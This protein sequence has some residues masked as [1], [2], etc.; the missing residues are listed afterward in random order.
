MFVLCIYWAIVTFGSLGKPFLCSYISQDYFSPVF[1]YSLAGQSLQEYKKLST[2]LSASLFLFSSVLIHRPRS[3]TC[4]ALFQLAFFLQGNER[5]IPRKSYGRKT[6]SSR[7]IMAARRKGAM[8]TAAWRK[9][10]LM[11]LYNG[12]KSSFIMTRDSLKYPATSRF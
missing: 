11:Y 2:S 6:H 1:P 3:A 10:T 4:P 5:L 7:R 8:N 9:I 12:S